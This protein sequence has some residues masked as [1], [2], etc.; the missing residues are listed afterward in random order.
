[1]F[2]RILAALALLWSLAGSTCAWAAEK[3][4]LS[5]HPQSIVLRGKAARQ[6]VILTAVENGRAVDRTRDGQYLSE[7]PAVVRVSAEGIVT[8]VADGTATVVGRF[9]DSEARVTVQVIQGKSA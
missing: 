4:T 3:V 8:P 5:L 1:M 7:N 2:R 6:Q 9:N